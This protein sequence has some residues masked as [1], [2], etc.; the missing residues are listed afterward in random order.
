MRA[1]TSSMGRSEGRHRS[2][3]QLGQLSAN[4]RSARGKAARV[5]V[6]LST[7]ASWQRPPAGPGPVDLLEEQ[8]RTRVPELVPIRHGRML[9]SASSYYRGAALPMA[10]DLGATPVTGFTVQVCGDAHL[11]NFGIFGSPE[12]H[13]F[14]DVNDFDETVPGPWEWDVKRLMASLEVA[15]RDNGFAVSERRGIVRRAA[16]SYRETIREFARQSMLEVWYAHLDM[17][18]LAPRLSLAARRQEDTRRL[19]RRDE[20]PSP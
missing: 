9:A 4:E 7:H 11:G 6:P 18:Q 2:D 17:A 20:R 15:G 10:S 1:D 8:A 3:R 19:A 5:E 12:R 13:L 16:R 14:F